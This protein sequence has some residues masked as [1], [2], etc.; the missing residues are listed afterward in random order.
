[1]TTDEARQIPVGELKV[2]PAAQREF[3]PHFADRLAANFDPAAIG[4]L[5]VNQRDDHYYVMDGQHRLAALRT[6]YADKIDDLK[7]DCRVYFDMTE[8]QEAEF[9][10]KTNYTLNVSAFDKHRVGVTAGREEDLAIEQ[11]C[12]MNG[13][14]VSKARTRNAIGAVGTLRMIYRKGGANTLARTLAVI[15][16]AYAENALSKEVMLGIALLINRY[17]DRIADEALIQALRTRPRGISGLMQTAEKLHMRTGDP[18]PACLAAAA[19]DIYNQA[20]ASRSKRRLPS[21]WQTGAGPRIT[22]GA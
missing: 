19:V 9:F 15:T 21:W 12:Q 13:C 11:I 1:M 2:A 5:F 7:V 4:I 20:L 22:D 14:T 17:G 18:R 16:S 10:L 8:Q 6:V 3:R